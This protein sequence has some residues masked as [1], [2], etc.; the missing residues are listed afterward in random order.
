M[1]QLSVEQKKLVENNIKL[2][3][4]IVNE[5]G[6]YKDQEEYIT[7]YE[8]LVIAALNYKPEFSVKFATYASKC[9]LCKIKEYNYKWRNRCT[10]QKNHKWTIVPCDS[11]HKPIAEDDSPLSEIIPNT[12][13]IS[14]NELIERI[15]IKQFL[16]KLSKRD[17]SILLLK[18]QGVNQT[19]IA[20]HYNVTQS[21]IS[22]ILTKLRKQYAEVI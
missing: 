8:Q 2:A 21:Y 5:C 18:Y 14:E 1:K 20:K 17:K 19:E 4:Y 6:I 10:Y 7:A 15:N 13:T 12:R 3:S 22:K 9:I 11:L 16:N